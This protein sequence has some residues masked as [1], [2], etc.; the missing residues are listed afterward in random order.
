MK[1]PKDILIIDFEGLKEPVQVGAILL[2]KDTLEERDSYSSY[3]FTD[4]KGEVKK[5]LEFLTKL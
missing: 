4:L 2:D 1:F 5:F 3:I